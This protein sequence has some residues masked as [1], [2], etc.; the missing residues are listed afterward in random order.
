MGREV[1][2]LGGI[3]HSDIIAVDVPISGAGFASTSWTGKFLED[4]LPPRL[5]GDQKPRL[6]SGMKCFQLLL[7]GLLPN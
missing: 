3:A 5:G 1:F 4:V 7:R 2:E 6:G